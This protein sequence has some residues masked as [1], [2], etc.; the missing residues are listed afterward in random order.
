MTRWLFSFFWLIRCIGQTPVC[1]R[2]ASRLASE[3]AGGSSF[4]ITATQVAIV[5]FIWSTPL[6]QLTL[7]SNGKGLSGSSSR[8]R[9]NGTCYSR[10]GPFGLSRASVTHQPGGPETVGS[11]GGGALQNCRRNDEAE[12]RICQV[13][14]LTVATRPLRSQPGLCLQTTIT[15]ST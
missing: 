6:R 13:L 5:F 3:S 2:G 10:V 8:K 7:L 15:P 9:R 11:S 4:L 12:H 14:T 1:D